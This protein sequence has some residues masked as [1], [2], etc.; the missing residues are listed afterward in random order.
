[1]VQWRTGFSG[2]KAAIIALGG[3]PEGRDA[4][5]HPIADAV[6]DVVENV[7]PVNVDVPGDLEIVGG[8]CNVPCGCVLNT[9]NVRVGRKSRGTGR[10]TEILCKC[11]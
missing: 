4:S 2:R 10:T 6:G 5:V 7:V 9:G 11:E 8:E 1:M 3:R